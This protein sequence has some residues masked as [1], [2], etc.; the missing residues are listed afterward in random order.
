M[1]PPPFISFCFVKN[2][3]ECCFDKL[4]AL[5]QTQVHA[6]VGGCYDF[7]AKGHVV[8]IESNL[9]QQVAVRVEPV[10]QIVFGIE[11]VN[12]LVH[13]LTLGLRDGTSPNADNV[14]LLFVFIHIDDEEVAV[15]L[16]NNLTFNG[17]VIQI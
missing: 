7:G 14:E 5:L 16:D 9:Y 1:S 10:L 2:E 15:F 8:G 6:L 4:F 3:S 13:S 12:N 17:I 11:F